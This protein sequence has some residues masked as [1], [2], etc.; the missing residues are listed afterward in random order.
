L[1]PIPKEY[2]PIY[3]IILQSKPKP[4]PN[5]QNLKKFKNYKEE[6]NKKE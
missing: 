3:A 5:D 2:T 6:N 4:N 1:K